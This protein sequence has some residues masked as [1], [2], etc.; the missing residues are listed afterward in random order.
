MPT[1]LRIRGFILSFVSH[2][3]K[4]PPH[5]HIERG[6]ALANIWLEQAIV[7]R[8]IGFAPRELADMVWLVRERRGAL[9]EGWRAH[10]GTGRLGRHTDQDCLGHSR[11]TGCWANG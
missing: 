9:P 6:G 4:E 8:N 5:V 10:F 7:A 2:D 1:I 3:R 11:R